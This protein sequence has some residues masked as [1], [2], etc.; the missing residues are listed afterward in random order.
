L[1]P[2]ALEDENS[3]ITGMLVIRAWDSKS[4][5]AL[6]RSMAAGYSGVENPLYFK[7]NTHMLFGDAKNSLCAVFASLG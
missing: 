5:V 6:K 4:V 1:N 2:S 7:N 3:L